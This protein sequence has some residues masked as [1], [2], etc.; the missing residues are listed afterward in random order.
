MAELGR[1]LLRAK[2]TT[3]GNVVCGDVALLP[4]SSGHKSVLSIGGRPWAAATVSVES[5][6]ARLQKVAY[7]YFGKRNGRHVK[8]AQIG[9]HH[10]LESSI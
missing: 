3:I 9:Y 1:P 5:M 7:L 4:I 10:T 2:S 8:K 6:P